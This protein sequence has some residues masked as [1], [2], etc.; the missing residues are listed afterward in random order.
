MG[1]AANARAA[2]Q[3]ALEIVDTNAGAEDVELAVRLAHAEALHADGDLDGAKC[4]L[5]IAKRSLEARAAA[6]ADG[7]MRSTF[8]ERVPVNARI[9][10]LDRAWSGANP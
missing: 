9:L 4:A 5:A 2:A 3:E 7:P 1:Q 8:L 10:Q 6:I